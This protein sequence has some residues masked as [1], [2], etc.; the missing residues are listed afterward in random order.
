LQQWRQRS[1]GDKTGSKRQ[2]VLL[3]L[4]V[5]TTMMHDACDVFW[6]VCSVAAA[7]CLLGAWQ[8]AAVVAQEWIPG[9]HRSCCSQAAAVAA[10]CGLLSCRDGQPGR[11]QQVCSCGGP[12]LLG[13][14][15]AYSKVKSLIFW[16]RCQG[17]LPG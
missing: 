10:A 7:S 6:Q 11:R 17:G 14:G 8:E 15:E 2:L 4:L 13:S 16:G 1:S 3:P 5:V 12:Q 9:S